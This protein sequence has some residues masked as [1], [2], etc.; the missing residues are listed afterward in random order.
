[1][2]QGY[3]LIDFALIHWCETYL[4]RG[5]KHSSAPS[6]KS[7]ELWL[8]VLV[9]ITLEPDVCLKTSLLILGLGYSLVVISLNDTTALQWLRYSS[10]II[11][12]LVV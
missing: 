9:I 4:R 6:A 11:S 2:R 10:A 5:G 7:E 8:P 3:L 12:S 1:M